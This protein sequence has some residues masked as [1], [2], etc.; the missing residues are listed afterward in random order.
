MRDGH[1][2]LAL[3]GALRLPEQ[4]H[5][6]RC[7]ARRHP[8]CPSVTKQQPSQISVLPNAKVAKALYYA[9]PVPLIYVFKLIKP[10]CM[11]KLIIMSTSFIHPRC[12]PYFFAVIFYITPP[13]RP[14]VH[15]FEDLPVLFW[16]HKGQQACQ[17]EVHN[18]R[19]NI[20]ADSVCS[21][22]KSRCAS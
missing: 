12:P 13:I 3:G 6:H 19:Q 7:P 22:S 17:P 15:H 10:S 18:M 14:L 21:A 5:G 8:P 4:A 16:I 9:C 11:L 1:E 20:G 2:A